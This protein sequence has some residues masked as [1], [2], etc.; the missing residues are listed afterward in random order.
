[1]SVQRNHLEVLLGH[2]SFMAQHLGLARTRTPAARNLGVVVIVQG[3]VSG[4]VALGLAGLGKQNQLPA[5]ATRVENP[6][7]SR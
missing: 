4:L 7:L 6:T 3:G 5:S 2:R 1:M